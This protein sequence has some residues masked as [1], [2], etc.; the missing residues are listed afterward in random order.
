MAIGKEIQHQSCFKDFKDDQMNK[1][2]M[3]DTLGRIEN[4]R[5][6]LIVF[7]DNRMGDNQSF[8][9]SL[10]FNHVENHENGFKKIIPS[11]NIFSQ[12]VRFFHALL[13]YFCNL[14]SQS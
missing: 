4:A 7:W 3:L 9:L 2:E 1:S 12:S 13:K 10:S 5:N 6:P 14:K 8:D 11:H